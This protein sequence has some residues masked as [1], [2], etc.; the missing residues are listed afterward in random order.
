[1]DSNLIF[2][3]SSGDYLN[4][5]YNQAGDFYTGDLLFDQNSSDTFKTIGLYLFENIPWLYYTNQDDVT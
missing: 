1:M 4:F 3:N 2:F 5:Q